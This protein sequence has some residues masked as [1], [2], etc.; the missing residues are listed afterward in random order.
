L[1]PNKWSSKDIIMAQ[2]V[3]RINATNQGTVNTNPYRSST[4]PVPGADGAAQRMPDN[5][6][7]NA[8]QNA[9]AQTP[10]APAQQPSGA[11]QTQTNFGNNDPMNDDFIKQQIAAYVQQQNGD[12]GMDPSLA[13]DPDY[14]VGV[15]KKSGGWQG[16]NIPYWQGKF[17]NARFETPGGGGAGGGGGGGAYVP[18]QGVPGQGTVFGAGQGMNPQ[19]S[20]LEQQLLERSQQNI[21]PDA[22]D[23]IIKHQVDAFNAQQQ[24][25]SRNY[26]A[27]VAEKAG[28]NSNIGSETRLANQQIG[29]AT[30]GF[31]AQLMG[32]ELTARRQE[33]QQALQGR[34]GLLTAQQQMQLQEELAQLDLAQRAYQSDQQFSYLNSPL[35]S[36]AMTG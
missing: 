36:G 8:F 23:P 28:P 32:Q 12:P 25:A 10:G 17:K 24:Q 3:Q 7:Q 5:P 14:W 31:E 34:Q 1:K 4:Q 22:N 6:S 15:I 11:G 29:Q 20:A 35:A 26:L 9:P 19:I 13:N 16:G 27:G 30:G 33:V 2:A 18:G 21:V